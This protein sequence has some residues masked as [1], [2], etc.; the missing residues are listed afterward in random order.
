M[1]KFGSTPQVEYAIITVLDPRLRSTKESII[2][3]RTIDLS[4][5]DLYS[6][7]LP[8]V[9]ERQFPIGCKFPF[10]Y[11]G[12]LFNSC[13]D[14]LEENQSWVP[15][16]GKI[17]KPVKICSILGQKSAVTK[18]T[19]LVC[20]G[21]DGKLRLYIFAKIF[22]SEI[23]TEWTT[24]PSLKCTADGLRVRRQR[25]CV[26]DEC[27]GTDIETLQNSTCQVPANTW[28]EWTIHGCSSSCG[29]GSWLHRRR[30]PSGSCTGSDSRTSKFSCNT[31]P[32]RKTTKV[33]SAECD[34]G[35]YVLHHKKRFQIRII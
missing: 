31:Q 9:A 8:D 25:Y 3:V 12:V 20:S 33:C 6:Q 5:I 4:D 18:D 1:P 34:G 7:F 14:L 13:A 11:H 19:F 16:S 27:S 32:C 29:G 23:W 22:C 15:S 21:L 24:D 10:Y 17:E 35:V 30:C 2:G 28:S 26:K